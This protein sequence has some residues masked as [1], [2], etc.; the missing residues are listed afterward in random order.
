MFP[1][2]IGQRVQPSV[3]S[4]RLQKRGQ[5]LPAGH[6]HHSQPSIQLNCVVVS[7]PAGGAQRNARSTSN[8]AGLLGN[9]PTKWARGGYGWRL[10]SS[11]KRPR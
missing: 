5:T 9:T 8:R 6:S 10:L 2:R 7:A 3:L 1:A 11:I 4:A